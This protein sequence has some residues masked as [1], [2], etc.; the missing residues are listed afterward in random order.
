M[1]E[2]IKDVTSFR[3]MGRNG[4]VDEKDMQDKGIQ[5]VVLRAA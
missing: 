3:C 2:L 5:G 4:G 1:H